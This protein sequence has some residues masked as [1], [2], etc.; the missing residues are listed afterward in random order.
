[1]I[2]FNQNGRLVFPDLE[3]FSAQ[4]TYKISWKKHDDT[5]TKQGLVFQNHYADFFKKYNWIND[6]EYEIPKIYMFELRRLAS[7]AIYEWG[8]YRYGDT[9]LTELCIEPVNTFVQS[10]FKYLYD[11]RKI[12]DEISNKN[13]KIIIPFLIYR[14]WYRQTGGGILISK[15]GID[16]YINYDENTIEKQL[17][18]NAVRVEQTE[19]KNI[20]GF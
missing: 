9:Y 2:N 14:F 8:L 1:M 16:K 6:I 19:L 13:S 3:E 17:Y 7:T 18:M 4:G 5:L 12:K 15:S 10:F 11:S 20:R